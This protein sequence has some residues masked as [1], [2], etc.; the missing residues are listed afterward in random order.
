MTRKRQTNRERD[1]CFLFRIGTAVSALGGFL[2]GF[3]PLGGAVAEHIAGFVGKQIQENEYIK[4]QDRMSVI[5]EFGSI[6]ELSDV[7]REIAGILADRYKEQILRLVDPPPVKTDCCSCCPWKEKTT[8][9]RSSSTEKPKATNQCRKLVPF[10]V[11]FLQREILNEES[12]TIGL[13][14]GMERKELVQGLVRVI[15]RAKLHTKDSFLRRLCPNKVAAL[16]HIPI[17][18]PVNSTVVISAWHTHDFYHRPDIQ[19]EK[20]HGNV[21]SRSFHHYG[22]RLGTQEEYDTALKAN[23]ENS[24]KQCCC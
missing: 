12:K 3:L 4:F 2:G 7:A 15:C 18:H 9:E 17:G 24:E 5:A 11:D 20:V 8:G 22:S 14:A 19:V 6:E 16:L 10:A 13:R 21:L 23:E 1:E